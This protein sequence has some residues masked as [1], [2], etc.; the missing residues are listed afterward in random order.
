[1]M[2]VL[3]THALYLSGLVFDLTSACLAYFTSRWFQR[4]TNCEKKLLQDVFEARAKETSEQASAPN[5][6]P[7]WSP[8]LKQYQIAPYIDNWLIAWY[9][10]SLF[11][12]PFFLA[13]G[14][15]C[16]LVGLY[17]HTWSQY[18][19]P[20]AIVVTIA[21]ISTLPFI[22]GVLLIGRNVKRRKKI[23]RRLS[24]MQGDW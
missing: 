18:P 8:P 12:P 11:M 16:L 7:Q 24:R 17:I 1:T 5:P 13:S 21:G 14:A 3:A 15:L 22:I 9:S 10:I 2:A 20:V 6:K 19:F 4:L 23:I